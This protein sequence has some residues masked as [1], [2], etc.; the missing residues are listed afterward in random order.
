M[1]ALVQ[2]VSQLQVRQLRHL[3]DHLDGQVQLTVLAAKGVETSAQHNAQTL[4]LAPE[5]E[6][7]GTNSL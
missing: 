3:A 4:Q 2:L 7:N 6:E 1:R 5:P